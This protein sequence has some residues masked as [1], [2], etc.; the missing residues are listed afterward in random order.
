MR[1]ELAVESKIYICLH[2]KAIN[3]KIKCTS[4]KIPNGVLEGGKIIIVNKNKV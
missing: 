1:F 3:I 4:E 2:K